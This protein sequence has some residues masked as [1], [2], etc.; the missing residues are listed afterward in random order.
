[1]K[2]YLYII[3]LS[4]FCSVACVNGGGDN[5]GDD[6][7][8]PTYDKVYD[9]LVGGDYENCGDFY[10]TGAKNWL[11]ELYA[12]DYSEIVRLEIQTPTS[13]TS[14]VGD[15]SI[16]NSREAQSA[17]SG[18]LDGAVPCGCCWV[19]Y[20]S[21]GGFAEYLLFVS[22]RI[23]IIKTNGVYSIALEAITSNG[24]KVCLYYNGEMAPWG[25]MAKGTSM[26]IALRDLY[27]AEQ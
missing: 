24:K 19:R 22:G 7:D 5:G 17:V 15:Y 14:F 12:E 18:Y 1:M 13:A 23:S 25:R 21:N 3:L 16:N 20:G 6:D 4:L 10:N 27:L 8:T 9:N 26:R 11:V 2:R